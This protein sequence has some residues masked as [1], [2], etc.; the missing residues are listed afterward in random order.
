MSA[1]A[2]VS[3]DGELVVPERAAISVFDRGLLYGDGLFEVLRTWSGVPVD[4]DAHLA[5]M[6][7]AAATIELRVAPELRAWTLR[8]LAATGP[9][10]TADPAIDHRIRLVVTRGPG[11]LR[12]RLASLTAGRTIIIVEPLPPIPAEV[13]LTVVEHPPIGQ[14]PGLKTLSYLDHLLAREIAASRGADD[15]IR[16]DAH[17]DIA[18]CATSNLF[19]V[20][21]GAVA[22]PPIATGALPGIVRA[23]T[24]ALCARL[25]IPA[26]ARRLTRDELRAADELFVTSS[27]RGVVAVT[28]LDGD[29]RA[30]GPITARLAAEHGTEMSALATASRDHRLL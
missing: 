16:L 5:R 9:D 26:A 4:L 18:E 15:A 30:P 6:R 19:A 3:I 21:A 10:A 11:A 23:R 14:G 12:E 28:A 24:L 2:C 22:T 27:L 17:G 29:R 25:G 13:R 1:R 7:E 8:T 20:T